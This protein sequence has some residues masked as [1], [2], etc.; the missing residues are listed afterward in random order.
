MFYR[1]FH[2][3]DNNVEY[4]ISRDLDSIISFREEHP[5]NEWCLSS[6]SLDLIRDVYPG[7]RHTIMGG[8]LG[9]KTDFTNS[10]AKFNLN[11]NDAFYYEPWK[12]YCVIN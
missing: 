10:S 11:E 12:E 4:F 2:F 3:L 8:M 7:H 5:V 1:F 6:K 9:F